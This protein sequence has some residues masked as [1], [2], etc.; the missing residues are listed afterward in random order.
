MDDKFMEMLFS[1]KEKNVKYPEK[2]YLFAF[3]ILKDLAKNNKNQQKSENI[4]A[5]NL[6]ITFRN[7]ALN[8]FGPMT[9]SVLQEW[10]ICSCRDLGN[11]IFDLV[12]AG[13]L[14]KDETDRIE[15]FE[16][17]YDFNEAFIHP[18]LPK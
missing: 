2:A 11:V 16:E 7:Y 13:V 1:I 4:K 6:L 14:E 17:I 8:E 15:D 9:A 10:N 5:A 18:Y 12:N 3:K